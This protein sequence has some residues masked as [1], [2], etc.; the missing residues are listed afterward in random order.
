MTITDDKGQGK[1][2]NTMGISYLRFLFFSV[3][4][5]FGIN[6]FSTSSSCVKSV[7]SVQQEEP[8]QKKPLTL[9]TVVVVFVV[10]VVAVIMVVVLVL[11]G[12]CNF[13]CCNSRG[14]EGRPGG[15]K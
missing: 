1:E 7:G 3:F 14:G 10:V 11:V 13:P 8:M 15:E 4:F 12:C 6:S 9:I 5:S 2:R